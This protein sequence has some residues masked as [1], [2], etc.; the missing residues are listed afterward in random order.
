MGNGRHGFL[1]DSGTGRSPERTVP[2]N[3]QGIEENARARRL[4]RPEESEWTSALCGVFRC[5]GRRLRG[6]ASHQHVAL[7]FQDENLI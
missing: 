4:C 7:P 3:F 2:I 5:P 6:V 1:H